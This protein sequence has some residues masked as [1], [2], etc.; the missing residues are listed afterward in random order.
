MPLYSDNFF[1]KLPDE[2]HLAVREVIKQFWNFD[3]AQKRMAVPSYDSYVT[4]Y[5]VLQAVGEVFGIPVPEVA[6][7]DDKEIN[8][9]NI[10]DAFYSV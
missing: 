2:P 6:F 5:A 9:T 3:D 7:T 8:K 10:R 4:A 1:D